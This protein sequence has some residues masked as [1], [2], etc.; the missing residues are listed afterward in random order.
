M[1]ACDTGNVKINILVFENEV[2]SLPV[3][4]NFNN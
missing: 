4:F 1:G 3:E 2:F